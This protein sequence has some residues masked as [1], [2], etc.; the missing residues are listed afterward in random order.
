M[1]QIKTYETVDFKYGQLL[2]NY[3]IDRVDDDYIIVKNDE[4]LYGLISLHSK[5]ISDRGCILKYEMISEFRE[6]I[7]IAKQKG[8][9]YNLIDK[10]GNELLELKAD[11]V[12]YFQDD[13]YKVVINNDRYLVNKAGQITQK[14][15]F[16]YS[17]QGDYSIVFKNDKKGVIDRK[18]QEI[19]HLYY[20]N[21]KIV[22][23]NCAI[24]DDRKL[25]SLKQPIKILFE[26]KKGKLKYIG[27]NRLLVRRSVRR[28]YQIIDFFGNTINKI[29]PIYLEGRKNDVI[30]AGAIKQGLMDLD[31]NYLIAQEYDDISV[32]EEGLVVG[33]YGSNYLSENNQRIERYLFHLF[34]TKGNRVL[35]DN[36]FNISRIKESVYLLSKNG[37]YGFYNFKTK[38]VVEPTYQNLIFRDGLFI[39]TK[40]NKKGLINL[41][42]KEV[43]PFNY[44]DINYIK[45]GI[46][47][48]TYSGS[49]IL[50]NREG[51]RIND[52]S[53]IQVNSFID[54]YAEFHKDDYFGVINTKGKEIIKLSTGPWKT[55]EVKNNLIHLTFDN[56]YHSLY[57]INGNNIFQKCQFNSFYILNEE[58][59]IIDNYLFSINQIKIQYAFY[60]QGNSDFKPKVFSSI[61]DRKHYIDNLNTMFID[62]LIEWYR[63]RQALINV[64]KTKSSE[65]LDQLESLINSST[66][67]DIK[68][69][70]KQLE[71]DDNTCIDELNQKTSAK[72]KQIKTKLESK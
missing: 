45:D 36:Y 50:F 39:A 32:Y 28:K 3:E 44:R 71:E 1:Q 67:D 68:S 70:V 18:G 61:D 30:I 17:F 41:E 72:V 34:D 65:Q 15:D 7:A 55:K 9:I 13:M 31:G 49:Y 6:G 25:I 4:V 62:N 47:K 53:Y 60:I 56:K 20:N 38:K 16:I 24:L 57:D 29:N 46:F 10:E 63:E 58:T 51:R 69:I 19:I 40:N 22:G 5:I 37:L 66:N 12:E 35:N 21:I 23:D 59:V 64:F 14:Y 42:E 48:A 54:G 52:Q 27:T 26:L 8:N 43:L 33:L 11:Y 2:T